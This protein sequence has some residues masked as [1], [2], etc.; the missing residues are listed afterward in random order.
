MSVFAYSFLISVFLFGILMK[1]LLLS[2]DN[3]QPIR[4]VLKELHA[5]KAGTPT[6]GG[7]IIFAISFI[8]AL[9]FSYK[10]GVLNW[11][12]ICFWSVCL[13]CSAIGIV[14]DYCKIYVNG[15]V[16]IKIRDKFMLQGLGI[17]CLILIMFVGQHSDKIFS[18][19]NDSMNVSSC[20][21]SYLSGLMSLMTMPH[22]VAIP[23]TSINV[24]IPVILYC[25]FA[26]FIVMSCCN[27]VNLTDGL[28]GLAATTGILVLLF[29]IIFAYIGGDATLSKYFGVYIDEQ[30]RFLIIS[31]SAIAGGFLAFLWYNCSPASIFMGDS[32]S[33]FLGAAIGM[34]AVLLRQE[35]IMI[36]LGGIF[37]IETA[38]S[39]IQIFCYKM[40]NFR[41]FL[42]TPI[43]HHFERMG[44]K[45]TKVS[46][47][48][49]I[50]AV[51]LLDI[52]LRAAILS[53]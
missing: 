43:H 19:V 15:T 17:F 49:I 12:F 13:Y 27:S 5:Q 35:L 3:K 30:A 28:D 1:K 4:N 40:W 11:S 47:R 48:F 36:I 31:C 42:I 39:M 24:T 51:I 52:S 50:V 20:A 23:Y 2:K 6:M 25:V 18:G 53:K 21:H 46:A 32:G 38:S 37:V 16:G 8:M 26:A 10:E 9:I 41:P 22:I 45:E 14:D 29:M 33:L 44:W 34:S 7:V